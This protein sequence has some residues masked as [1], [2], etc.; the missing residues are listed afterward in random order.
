MYP[1]SVALVWDDELA[2][3]NDLTGEVQVFGRDGKFHRTLETT[4]PLRSIARLSSGPEGDLYAIDW[5]GGKLCRV[6]RDGR[7][8]VVGSGGVFDGA[9]RV[10]FTADGKLLVQQDDRDAIVLVDKQGK[11]LGAIVG[12][13][14]KNMFRWPRTFAV[15]PA[16]DVLVVDWHGG[17][18]FC[19]GPDLKFKGMIDQSK[20]EDRFRARWGVSAVRADR[21]GNVFLL[22]REGSGIQKFG[23]DGSYIMTILLDEAEHGTFARPED[24]VLD[25]DGTIYAADTGNNRV[26]KFI[27]TRPAPKGV[28]GR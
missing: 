28:P 1:S 26:L 7:L 5:F 8:E 21:Q 15:T 25:A 9:A 10:D 2:A 20:V 6:N 11:E 27:P 14:G 18:V 17:N 19:Y 13:R 12:G 24:L 3:L 23:P 16:R 22:S 4:P